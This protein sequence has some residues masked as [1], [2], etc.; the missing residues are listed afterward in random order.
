MKQNRIKE[1]RP[2]YPKKLIR[3]TALAAAALM[4]IGS[5]G[6]NLK[7]DRTTGFAPDPTPGEELTID[8]EIAIEPPVLMG[9]PTLDEGYDSAIQDD[10][11]ALMGKIAVPEETAKP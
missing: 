5:T 6:C 7:T 4:A 1:Y 11:P 8:G 3:G 9:E 10:E 2:A